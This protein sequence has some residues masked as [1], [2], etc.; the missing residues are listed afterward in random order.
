MMSDLK[1]NHSARVRFDSGEPMRVLHIE[2]DPAHAELIRRGFE[3]HR[4]ASEIRHFDNGPEAIDYL[5][6]RGAYADPESSPT[7]DVVLLDLR[8]PGMDGLEILEQ[9]RAEEMTRDL[10]V[11]ILTTS[12]AEDDKLKSYRQQING[13]VVKPMDFKGFGA[14]LDV[15]YLVLTE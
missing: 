14:L 13:Y 6:R 12:Q 11:V 7:P 8:L 2:D 15:I 1:E 4:R 9:L 3:E 5:L 10:P